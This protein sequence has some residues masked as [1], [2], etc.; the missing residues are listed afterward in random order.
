MARRSDEGSAVDVRQ[1]RRLAKR[2]GTT[3]AQ[4]EGTPEDEAMDRAR[5]GA[6]QGGRMSGRVSAGGRGNQQVTAGNQRG[7]GQNKSGQGGLAMHGSM[8]GA[9]MAGREP[10]HT[11]KTR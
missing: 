8:A 3:M 5:Q 4:V 6:R 2:L 11:S 10:R 7:G 9:R 1:D